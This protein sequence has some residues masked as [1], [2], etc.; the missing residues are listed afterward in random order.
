MVTGQ[1]WSVNA[2]GLPS[3]SSTG[4]EKGPPTDED[5]P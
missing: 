5:V 2:P 3:Q 1:G 4:R